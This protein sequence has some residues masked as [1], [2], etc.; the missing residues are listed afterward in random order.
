MTHIGQEGALGRGR[1]LGRFNRQT[2][3]LLETFSGPMGFIQGIRQGTHLIMTMDAA[4]TT[5]I[6]RP[7][8][9]G[10]T[11]AVQGPDHLMSNEH[12]RQETTPQQ[13]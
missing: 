10:L 1:L 8:P 7:G 5:Q 13:D 6:P 2:E 12:G 4:T 9:Q 3:F 11:E